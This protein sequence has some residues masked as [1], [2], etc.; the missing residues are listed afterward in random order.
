VRHLAFIILVVLGSRMAHAGSKVE[1]VVLDGSTLA[2]GAERVPLRGVYAPGLDQVCLDGEAEWPCGR[3]AAVALRDFV[4]ERSIRCDRE[5]GEP[6]P[7]AVCRVGED[8]LNRWLVAEGWGLADADAPVAYREAE[9][10]A[11]AAGKGIWRGGFSPSPA[12]RLRASERA[13]SSGSEA[14]DVCAMRHR[15]FNRREKTE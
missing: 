15:A 2:I 1:A 4:G 5:A 13:R 11:V 7:A 10:S 8:E 3:M 12:W 9:G 14:C 6:S